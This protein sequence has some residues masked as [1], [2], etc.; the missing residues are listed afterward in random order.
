MK[1]SHSII[2]KSEL[3]GNH[4]KSDEYDFLWSCNCTDMDNDFKYSSK[5][6]KGYMYSFDCTD[7]G[8]DTILYDRFILINPKLYTSEELEKIIRDVVN[9]IK[10]SEDNNI[11]DYV[12]LSSRL[13][14]YGFSCTSYADVIY[15]NV[16]VYKELKTRETNDERLIREFDKCMQNG[17]SE[18][19]TLL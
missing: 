14:E 1:M 2:H 16:G 4:E 9:D 17:R 7:D 12:T 10:S 15:N 19:T 18:Q 3:N 8:G 5:P 6:V 13:K 11:V